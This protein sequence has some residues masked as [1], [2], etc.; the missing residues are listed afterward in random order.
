MMK[1][2]VCYICCYCHCIPRKDQN[3]QMLGCSDVA[4][5]LFMK[6]EIVLECYSIVRLM[7]VGHFLG[8]LNSI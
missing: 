4:H 3:Q 2:V 1:R 7:L 8:F 5:W 6:I